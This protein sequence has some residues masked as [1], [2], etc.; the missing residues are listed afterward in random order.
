MNFARSYANEVQQDFSTGYTSEP[1]E[2]YALEKA[3]RAET[4]A[5]AEYARILAI[6]RDLMLHGK[7]PHDEGPQHK[8]AGE[9]E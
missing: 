8:T 5:V 6:F 1:Q 4:A 2:H 3:L 7:L 9:G